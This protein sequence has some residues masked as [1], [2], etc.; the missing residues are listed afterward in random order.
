MASPVFSMVV[1]MLSRCDL[2]PS[3]AEDKADAWPALVRPGRDFHDRSASA[4][5]PRHDPTVAHGRRLDAVAVSL[6]RV[7][8]DARR[9]IGRRRP[10]PCAIRSTST[11]PISGGNPREGCHAGQLRV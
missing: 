5:G 10:R 3:P 8:V 6:P 1:A 2:P 7:R 9:R 4:H 11:T